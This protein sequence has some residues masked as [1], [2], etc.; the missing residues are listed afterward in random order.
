MKRFF[1]AAI[2]A[3]LASALA[4]G[5]F[6]APETVSDPIWMGDLAD[7]PGLTFVPSANSEYGVYV[8]PVGGGEV[9]AE[10][11]IAEGGEIVSEGGAAWLVSGVE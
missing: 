7:F 6:A 5:A 1:I 3:I 10:A 9:H 11:E 8:F 4:V 2:W